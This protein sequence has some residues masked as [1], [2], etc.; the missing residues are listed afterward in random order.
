M[1]L[2]KSVRGNIYIRELSRFKKYKSMPK[3]SV[4][5]PTYNY[6]SYL[7]KAIES[8]LN[9]TYRDFELII[10]DN[11]ST[12][13]TGK[14]VS[15]YQNDSRVKYF[16]NAQNIGNINNFN[17]ALE[18]AN[19]EYIK[20][21]FSDDFVHPEALEDFVNVLDNNLSVSLVTS[22]FE[23]FGSMSKIHKQ[24]QVGKLSG[25]EAIKSTIINGNWIGSPSNVIFRKS[26]YDGN[27]F[28]NKWRWWSDL[29]FWHRIMG[30]GDL[31]VVP[32][33]L[34]GFRYHDSSATQDCLINFEDAYDEYYY[35]KHVSVNNLYSPLK[36]DNEFR[37]QLRI[38][39]NKWVSLIPRFVKARK[40]GLL[41]QA[42]M[43]MVEEGLVFE[44]LK[45]IPVRVFRKVY[46]F[47]KKE[48]SGKATVLFGLS[49]LQRSAVF[50]K[51]DLKF[52]KFP[53]V[54]FK[55]NEFRVGIGKKVEFRNYCNIMIYNKAKLEIGDNVFFN[56]YCSINCLGEIVIGDN[57][58][59]G[60]GVKFYDHNHEY[61]F[62]DNVLSVEKDKFSVG[63]I[64]VGKNCWIGSN[65][66]ILKGVVIGDNV[67]IGA[68]NLIYKS[69]PANVIVKAKTDFVI[70]EKGV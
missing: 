33:V 9:Q 21:L 39:A 43:V 49:K 26:C 42:V 4:L 46:S 18:Y 41:G 29:E 68:N 66:T 45:A 44:K 55:G 22:Y 60:E 47:F 19:G 15:F 37:S 61:C 65:V 28:S 50:F 36:Y 12:D 1:I 5:M 35:L 8:V 53:V 24:P 40:A 23:Y 3:V 7:A 64:R 16:R 2:A 30:V 54:D 51:G 57:C 31:Y 25:Y 67:I 27:G 52:G 14:I 38:N 20:F 58:L 56:N 6:G 32:K 13:D 62:Q 10:V 34:S 63:S 48:N 17:K 70:E 59:F 11:S 69:I